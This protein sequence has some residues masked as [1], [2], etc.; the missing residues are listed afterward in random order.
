MHWKRALPA[1][2]AVLLAAACAETGTTTAPR[3]APR[4]GPSLAV[5]P[6]LLIQGNP[7]CSDRIAGSKEL[8]INGA[9]TA[10]TTY[11]PVTIT[12]VYGTAPDQYGI[13]FTSVIPI[14]GVVMK[15]SDAGN[16]YDY[17]PNGTLGDNLLVTPE[18][19]SGGNAAIS[20]ISF[21][22]VPK[23]TVTKTANPT[24]DRDWDWTINKV[25]NSGTTAVNPLLLAQGQSFLV[26][27]TVSGGA[28]STD[29]NFAVTGQIT[30]DNPLFNGDAAI[31]TGV[32]DVISR[33][34]DADIV[35]V[36]TCAGVTF[37]HTL[38]A[39]GTLTC[40][41]AAALPNALQRLNTATA[42]VAANSLVAGGSGTASVLFGTTPVNQTD[43]CINV[44]DDL[45]TTVN[46]QICLGDLV[47]GQYSFKY[48]Y[49][50]RNFTRL[51]CDAIVKIRNVA[52]FATN[53]QNGEGD[54][55]GSSASDV[56][57]KLLCPTGCTLTQGYWKTHSAY[58]PAP[59]DD[60]WLLIGPNGAATPFF[61]TGK[62]WYQVF[63]TPPAGNAYYILAVQYMAAKL[64]ILNGAATTPAVNAAIAYAETLFGGLSSF[65]PA[66]TGALRTTILG[67]AS[68]LDQYNNGAI[69][70]G[71]CTER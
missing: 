62:T 50:V 70:P 12:K 11:G 1:T 60:A 4:A 16:F 29:H 40:T 61:G 68:T 22:Y 32:S 7:T 66:P 20:H 52:S 67:Y 42:S 21:C 48:S 14:L 19:A 28:T 2:A 57:V 65:T 63:W 33:A 31:V 38:A 34:G 37:P 59:F 9:P 45:V 25:N 71:H 64:N 58:G 15:G 54:D 8:K 13:D 46:R 30:V 23:L 41:Y 26:E 39:G 35:G 5:V 18:N 27:Y 24:F 51:V 43:T 10:G 6:A 69:G 17:R 44:T 3:P 49:D 53:N 47:G 56:W 36:V 55:T